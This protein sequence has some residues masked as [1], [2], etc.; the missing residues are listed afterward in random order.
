M[1]RNRNKP[2]ARALA[3]SLSTD[4]GRPLPS[5]TGMRSCQSGTSPN[6]CP[7]ASNGKYI[8]CPLLPPAVSGEM[9]SSAES[10]PALWSLPFHILPL[11]LLPRHG[12]LPISLW[13]RT[14][15]PRSIPEHYKRDLWSGVTV[16]LLPTYFPLLHPQLRHSP[17]LLPL[18]LTSLVHTLLSGS[19]PHQPLCHQ[20]QWE[21]PS[22]PGLL[23]LCS[24][25]YSCSH[26]GP[27][28]SW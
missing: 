23:N 15:P 14:H 12:H 28:A 19:S 13:T 22:P 27:T 20:T 18:C 9:P 16:G 3:S 21:H 26:A 24:I 2:S 7:N 8:T 17:S 4:R 5:F 10:F 25:G 1:S 11:Q 6:S